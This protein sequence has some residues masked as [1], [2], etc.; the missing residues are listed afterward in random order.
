MQAR[1][2][3]ESFLNELNRYQ[4]ETSI[5]LHMYFNRLF[6]KILLKKKRENYNIRIQYLCVRII[7]II[8][9]TLL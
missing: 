2:V 9:Y 7:Y 8:S 3:Q 4:S 6:L 1:L 5:N